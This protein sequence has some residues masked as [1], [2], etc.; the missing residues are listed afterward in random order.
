LDSQIIHQVFPLRIPSC[1][2]QLKLPIVNVLVDIWHAPL[3]YLTQVHLQMSERS[4]RHIARWKK[5]NLRNMKTDFPGD[6]QH[7]VIHMVGNAVM[8]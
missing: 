8:G 1:F 3:L 6:F 2:A 5:I 4:V 7:D